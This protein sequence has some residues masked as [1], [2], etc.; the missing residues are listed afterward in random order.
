MSA[1]TGIDQGRDSAER[2]KMRF[3]RISRARRSR[4]WSQEP[5]LSIV[6]ASGIIGAGALCYVLLASFSP[7]PPEVTLRHLAAFPNCA[8]ARAV[9]LAPANRGEPGYW[10]KHDRDRDG[11]ACEP[12]HG[13]R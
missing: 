3:A 9:G 2:L 7:W 11:V 1:R 5:L 8:A 13:R 6:I 10:A 12:W 4:G